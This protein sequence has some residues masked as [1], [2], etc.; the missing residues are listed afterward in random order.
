MQIIVIDD[1]ESHLELV[2]LF[3]ANDPDVEVL[4]T[5]TKGEDLVALLGEH[6][7]DVVLL[8]LSMPDIDGIT[9]LPH[10]TKAG[11]QV[12]ITTEN[13]FDPLRRAAMTNGALAVVAKAPTETLLAR[14][15]ETLAGLE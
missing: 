9:L 1:D 14:V 12:I 2:R 4:A 5:S 15:R 13:T 3:A 8:D 11:A 10:A 6:Q 7:P